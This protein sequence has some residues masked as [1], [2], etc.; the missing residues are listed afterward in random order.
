MDKALLSIVIP[1]YNAENWI[2]ETLD[3]VLA[4]TYTNLEVI[5]VDDGSRDNSRQIVLQYCE[6]DHRVR[7]IQQPNSGV[8]AA[9]NNGMA[10]SRGE[11]LGFID[12]DDIMLPNMYAVLIDLLE[13]EESDIAFCGFTRFFP[14]GHQLETR[15]LSFGK[16]K[17]NP[18]DI[19]Y[20]W[21]STPSKTDNGV[22]YTKDIHGS[23]WRSVF[24]R[25]IIISQNL[26]FSTRM[27]FSEDQVFMC[28]Y[29][30]CCRKISFTDQ[31]L[32][33]YRANTKPW[34]YHNL[35]HNDMELLN[36]QLQILEQNHYY[37]NKEKK[38][39]AGYLMC[40]AYF[41][42]INEE[43]M[44]KPDVAKVLNAY[45]QNPQFRELLTCYNFYQKQKVNGNWKKTVLFVLLK[46][47]LYELARRLFPDKRY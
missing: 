37:S 7:L 13:K 35:F 18:Q 34:K 43:F 6:K 41:M 17:E 22:L 27:R 25:D 2:A 1:V 19:K 29:L 26:Q 10:Q 47:R 40:S 38:Q 30:Q 9:R 28:Q 4:Q 21:Y 32:L 39:L 46:L 8:S 42:I 14:A 3:S 23:V 5:C 31:S 36:Q 12:A 16:L 20:F 45:N 33:R 15:E 24:K 11:Y 44:F